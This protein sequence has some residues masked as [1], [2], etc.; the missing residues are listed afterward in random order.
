MPTPEEVK[1]FRIRHNLTQT[2]LAKLLGYK[3]DR[4]IQYIESGKWRIREEVWALLL[5]S[6]DNGKPR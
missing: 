6:F 3:S 2:S 1:D 4:S 5:A